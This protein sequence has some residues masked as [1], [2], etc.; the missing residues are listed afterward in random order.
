VH[1]RPDDLK[2]RL[3]APWAHV[4]RVAVLTAHDRTLPADF[5]LFGHIQNA[6]YS[7]WLTGG[8][9]ARR[10]LLVRRPRSLRAPSLLRR[11]RASGSCERGDRE[12]RADRRRAWRARHAPLPPRGAAPS[13]YRARTASRRLCPLRRASA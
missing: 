10:A 5:T 11:S 6:H 3:E 4:V 12:T 8:S 2:V 7:G 1:D 13:P 9:I